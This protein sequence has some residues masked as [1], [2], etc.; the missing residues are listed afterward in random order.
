[1]KK[2]ISFMLAAVMLFALCGCGAQVATVKVN[3]DGSGTVVAQ[4]GYTEEGLK[5]LAEYGGPEFDDVRDISMLQPF[6][7]NGTT[8]YGYIWEKAFSQP[9]ELDLTFSES[10]TEDGVTMNYSETLDFGDIQ[11]ELLSNGDMLLLVTV[12]DPAEKYEAEEE[13][14]VEM[15]ELTAIYDKHKDDIVQVL[16]FEF[17]GIVQQTGGCFNGINVNGGKLTLDYMR[18]SA[19][20]CRT[21]TF[22]ISKPTTGTPP[23]VIGTRFEDVSADAW[24]APAVEF[25]ASNG[26]V[27]G[28]GSGKFG[29]GDSLTI[30]QFAQILARAQDLETGAGETGW[31]AEKALA[32]CLERGWITDRGEINTANY[33][34]T[35]RRQEAISAMQRASQ[36]KPIDGNNYTL[37]DIPDHENICEKYRNDVVAAYNSGITAGVDGIGTMLPLNTLTRAEVCQ[38]FY[39]LGWGSSRGP[40]YD[41]TFGFDTGAISMRVNE[42]TTLNL[43]LPTGVSDTSVVWASN[44]PDIASVSRGVILARTEGVAEITA[45]IPAMEGEDL[46]RTIGCVVTVTE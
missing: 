9:S 3:E 25:M 20:S 26:L 18:M 22:R 13:M 41:D 27:T 29:P 8:Y 11:L 31:W 4:I 10:S 45:T 24:Y 5:D 15:P 46:P 17:P 36:R 14:R 39:N 37:E 7:Y 2:I 43:T 32:A 21:Y 23:V 19:N 44:A 28:Y 1:M 34:T 38:L 35:I 40:D 30:A 6:I 12:P 16:S 33:D 42:K